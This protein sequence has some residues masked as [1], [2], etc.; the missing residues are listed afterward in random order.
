MLVG[1]ATHFMSAKSFGH[2]AQTCI[3]GLPGKPSLRINSDFKVELDFT[4]PL[5]EEAASPDHSPLGSTTQQQDGGHQDPYD[6]F[7]PIITQESIVEV[8]K[9]KL[10][11]MALAIM[12]SVSKRL[13]HVKRARRL[14][15]NV[16][17]NYDDEGPKPAPV[18]PVL[19]GDGDDP[20]PAPEGQINGRMLGHKQKPD[21]KDLD[22]RTPWTS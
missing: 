4:A 11:R 20:A 21:L 17:P 22:R 2:W 12:R 5:D 16:L 1:T 15:G 3:T 8:R 13:F 10:D 18:V 14:V 9:L 7:L 6:N 19:G